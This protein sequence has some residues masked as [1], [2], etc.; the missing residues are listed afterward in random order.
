MLLVK[1]LNAILLAT[2]IL[3]KWKK[4]YS[5]ILKSGSAWKNF[6]IS[7]KTITDKYASMFQIFSLKIFLENSKQQ[8]LHFDNFQQS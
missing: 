6:Q 5:S 4:G 7:S 3:E 8:D 2:S 1:D